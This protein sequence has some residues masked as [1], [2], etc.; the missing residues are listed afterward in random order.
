MCTNYNILTTPCVRTTKFRLRVLLARGRTA[1]NV[2]Y[3]SFRNII[4]IVK[5]RGGEVTRRHEVVRLLVS[6]PGAWTNV[7]TPLRAALRLTLPS[8]PTTAELN[9]NLSLRD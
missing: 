6:S 9:Y 7:L 5:V 8:S 4:I 2:P 3:V 1:P